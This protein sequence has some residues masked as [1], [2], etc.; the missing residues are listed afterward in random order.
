MN[1]VFRESGGHS[2]QRLSQTNETLTIITN[3]AIID[4]NQVRISAPGGRTSVTELFLA[5]NRI[6]AAHPPTGCGSGPST[7]AETYPFGLEA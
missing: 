4:V 1:C 3:K 7:A 6:P 5:T 2:H